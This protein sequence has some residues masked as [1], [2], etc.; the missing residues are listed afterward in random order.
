MLLAGGVSWYIFNIKLGS[1][2][3]GKIN[4]Q[5]SSRF[6]PSNLLNDEINSKYDVGVT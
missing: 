3:M 4:K 6:W 1:E 2:N 5:T